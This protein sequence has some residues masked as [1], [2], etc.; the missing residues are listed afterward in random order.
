MKS[1]GIQF[2]L[3]LSILFLSQ[4]ASA[5]TPEFLLR[6]HLSNGANGGETRSVAFGYDPA[7]Q[8][9]QCPFDTEA[10]PFIADEWSMTLGPTYF[11]TFVRQ[12]P[13]TDSFA[14]G[15]TWDLEMSD[16]PDTLTWNPASIPASITHIL[17]CP[18]GAPDQSFLDLVTQSS[19]V[20]TAANS[21]DLIRDTVT[22]YYNEQPEA[23]AKTSISNGALLSDFTAYPNPFDV[24]TQ[25]RYSLGH[26]ASMD[27]T[28]YD[29]SGRIVMHQ[30][31]KGAVGL[32][33]VALRALGAAVHGP[34]Y[35]RLQAVAE[36]KS[37]VKMLTLM[38]Q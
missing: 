4:T 13:S 9:T 14:I 38:A 33:S 31:S 27:I 18:T 20:M 8:D 1:R 15:F 21:L 22:I 37:E 16:Y 29:E 25:L 6:M 7:A 17:V 23:V 24:N 3:F 35:V 11:F 34:L 30:D 12:K 26:N 10:P 5:Q 19:F 32:N 28:I 36:G 2:F